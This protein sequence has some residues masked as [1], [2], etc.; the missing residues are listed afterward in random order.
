MLLKYFPSEEEKYI[1]NF[2]E[3]TKTLCEFANI[4]KVFY[5]PHEV[6]IDRV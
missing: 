5:F 6:F 3:K 1:K 2:R 4:L